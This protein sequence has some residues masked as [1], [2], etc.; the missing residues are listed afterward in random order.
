[1]R[2]ILFIIPPYF[3]FTSYNTDR[4]DSIPVFTI[5]YGILSI[6][7]YI[8]KNAN[9]DVFFEVLDLNLEA[10]KL[11]NEGYENTKITSLLISVVEDKINESKYDI[12][13]ISALFNNS[14]AYLDALSFA[15]K[16]VEEPPLCIVGGG[17][18]SNMYTEVLEKFENIDAVCLA[19]GENPMLDLINAEEMLPI[20]Q[21]HKSWITKDKINNNFVFQPSYIF[22]LDEIPI[23]QFDTIELNYYNGRSVDKKFAKKENRNIRQAFADY[24]KAEGCSCCRD[25]EG[26]ELANKR[27]AELLN[28]E[29]YEDG[30]GFNWNKYRTKPV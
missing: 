15:V 24:T 11:L 25:N 10:F 18:A 28:C 8:R 9:K 14:Y 27:L 26:H 13:G 3:S 2:N 12:V 23:L 20:L 22:D 29:K 21:T 1:M 5:P 7:S 16:S 19:E 17:L 6:I 4:L 30:S